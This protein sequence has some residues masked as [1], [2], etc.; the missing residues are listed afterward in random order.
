MCFLPL[1]SGEKPFYDNASYDKYRKQN[2]HPVRGT[3]HR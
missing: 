2:T 3:T 1:Y